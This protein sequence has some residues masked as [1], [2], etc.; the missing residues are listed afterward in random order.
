MSIIVLASVHMYKA[1]LGVVMW[2]PL[3]SCLSNPGRPPVTVC[4]ALARFPNLIR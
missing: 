3:Q 1:S 4:A 2:I